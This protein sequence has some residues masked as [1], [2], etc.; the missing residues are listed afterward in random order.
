V[1]VDM[2]PITGYMDGVDFFEELGHAVDGNRVYPSINCLEHSQPCV[3]KC[4]I[5]RVKVSLDDIIRVQD[6]TTEGTSSHSKPKIR[7][8]VLHFRDKNLKDRRVLISTRHDGELTE[9]LKLV[10]ET[11]NQMYSI[12]MLEQKYNY[13]QLKA[14]LQPESVT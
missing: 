7:Y 5:V 4:G 13:Y 11:G 3:A 12:S 1:T 2:T 14:E 10:R 8:H 6:F 9:I